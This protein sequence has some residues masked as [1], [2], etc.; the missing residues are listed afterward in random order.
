[1]KTYGAAMSGERLEDLREILNRARNEALARV[2]DLRRE[3]DEDALAPPADEMDTA[4]SLAEVETHASLIE[5][6]EYQLKAIAAAF[7][8]LEA[9]SYGICDDCHGEI[10]VERLKVMPFAT[11]CVGCQGKRNRERKPGEGE[12]DEPSRVLWRVPEEVDKALEKQDSLVEPEEQLMVREGEPLGMEVGEF[13]Q[14]VPSPTARRRG[15]IKKK[16][17]SEEEGS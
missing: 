3:Q 4:R 5:R 15:R 16:E 17:P 12:V 8:Q 6:V 2:R 1:M 13:E 10:A 11:R 14:L 9:G 7:S